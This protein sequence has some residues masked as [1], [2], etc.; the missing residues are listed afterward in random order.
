MTKENTSK[1]FTGTRRGDGGT[2]L[3]IADDTEEFEIAMHYACSLAQ[4]RRGH[5]AVAHITDLDDFVHWGKVETM[6]RHDL[7]A[8]AEQQIWKIAR[9]INE[10]YG[11]TP[12]LYIGEGK[13][14][15]KIVDIINE[16]RLIRS[17]ILAGSTSNGN[18][19]P[20]I[21]Y[22]SGKGISRLRAPIVIVP[23]HFD[24]EQ[25]EAVINPL[26]LE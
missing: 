17:L 13:P 15:D 23:G 14:L 12:S 21:T 9:T 20:L 19:G 25:I 26:R 18:P 5:V 3:I 1:A 8:Q 10:T 22:F 2:Y 11:L 7:R 24:K 6:M 4:T 16:E